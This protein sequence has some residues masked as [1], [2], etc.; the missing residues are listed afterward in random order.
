M[1]QIP[2]TQHTLHLRKT[3]K[4]LTTGLVLRALHQGVTET[5]AFLKGFNWSSRQLALHIVNK[6]IGSKWIS[7]LM[8][9]TQS[10]IKVVNARQVKVLT[11]VL[12]TLIPE[13]PKREVAMSL[14]GSCDAEPVHASILGLYLEDESLEVLWP[15]AA[16][17]GDAKL[18]ESF[19]A[20]RQLCD[21]R[22]V[23]QT[24]HSSG[25]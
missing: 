11:T 2:W 3:L 24:P 18:A 14:G 12:R 1:A 5:Q 22:E 21:P 16:Q 6:C 7:P 25:S 4:F 8:R 17:T 13:K 20:C 10:N 19:L 23:S 9:A 15:L